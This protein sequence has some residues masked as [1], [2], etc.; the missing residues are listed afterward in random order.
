MRSCH[1]AIFCSFG[2]KKPYIA[3][4]RQNSCGSGQF[5]LSQKFIKAVSLNAGISNKERLTLCLIERYIYN[6]IY[7]V[8]L[9]S[10][11]AK[12]LLELK[13]VERL[14]EDS[15]GIIIDVSVKFN[16]KQL[17]PTLVKITFD[18]V[19]SIETISQSN[20][21]PRE[22]L[23]A[24]PRDYTKYYEVYAKEPNSNIVEC[25]KI[26]NGVYY[27]KTQTF[28]KKERWTETIP[29]KKRVHVKPLSASV[30][31]YFERKRAK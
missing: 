11:D 15:C 1:D 24:I 21:T 26:Q 7:Q 14:C 6:K 2:I 18:T 27:A 16:K 5:T 30:L 9:G 10:Q 29:P 28:K 19:S 12:H 13:R 3:Y 4:H 25:D 23:N 8:I 31:A 22:M 20:L 17:L